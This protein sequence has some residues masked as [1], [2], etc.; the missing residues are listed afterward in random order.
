MRW[1][2]VVGISLELAGA[3]LVAWA[4]YARSPAENRQEALSTLG[5]NFWIILF[6]ERDQA[7]VRAGLIVLAIGF[8]VQL[9]GYLAGFSWPSWGL[10]LLAAAAT[11]GSAFVIAQKFASRAVPLELV[12]DEATDVIKD[13]RH[14]FGVATLDDVLLFRKLVADRLY[15]RKLRRR[16]Y[17]VSPRIS[18]GV[19]T[20]SCPECG[21]NHWSVATPDLSTAV[22]SSCSGEFP[23]RFPERRGEIERLLLARRDENKRNWQP[24]QAIDELRRENENLD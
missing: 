3:V 8:A 11:G 7:Y 23:A 20:F 18:A 19:W 22:C 13:E 17:I 12:R 1:L 10:A 15:G 6:R 14:G 21:S 5:S 4:V 9:A 16:V 2:F 24:G